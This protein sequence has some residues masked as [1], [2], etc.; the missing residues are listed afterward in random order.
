M[1]TLTL[2]RLPLVSLIALLCFGGCSDTSTDAP[3]GTSDS[4][5]VGDVVLFDAGSSSDD[6]GPSHDAGET[7]TT[8]TDA[9][10]L[11]AISADVATTDT[12]TVDAGTPDAGTPDSGTPDA[13]TPDAGTPDA[14]TPDAGTPDAGGMTYGAFTLQSCKKFVNKNTDGTVNPFISPARNNQFYVSWVQKSGDLML[15]WEAPGSCKTEKGPMQVNKTKGDVYYWGGIAVVSDTAGNFYA[16][17]ESKTKNA[18]ISIAWSTSGKDFSAPMEVVSTSTNGQDPALLVVSPG[19]VH[20]AWR[21]HHPTKKQ[22]DPYFATNVDLF[23]NKPFGK[24]VPLQDDAAQDDQV[25][26]ARDSKGNLYYAWQSH[27]GDMFAAKSTDGGKTWTKPVQ[28]NDVK[29]KAN[30]G[31]GTFLVV[32]PDDRVVLMWSDT[33]KKKSGNEND[34]FADSSAD[35]LTWGKDVQVNDNDARYQQDPSMAVGTGAKCK[36]AIY[37]V[38][39]DFRHKKSYDVY[40][41]RSIDGG[42]TWSKNEAIAKDLAEDEMNPAIAVDKGCVIGVAWRDSTKNKN[43]DI[44]LQFLTW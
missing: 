20:A 42:L 26:I 2:R 30:V 36:G 29:E 13:G 31:K 17:W 22:Y 40:A 15:N 35:G 5:A 24:G 32:T 44:G 4:G 1:P 43:F 3:A 37:A 21:G 12:E 23:K 25:A 14:G 38:W 41:A 18:D 16:V 27:D 9:G 11:D 8:T 10:A 39:Q 7:D 33:R 19:V 28:V 6:T 34:V